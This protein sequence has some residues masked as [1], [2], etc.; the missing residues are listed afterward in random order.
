MQAAAVRRCHLSHTR[1]DA[2]TLNDKNG[3]RRNG[4]LSTPSPATPRD[5]GTMM[6]YSLRSTDVVLLRLPSDTLA[7]SDLRDA[8]LPSADLSGKVC[9]GANFQ[10]ATLRRANFAGADLR[11]ADLS[12]SDLRGANLI[13]ADLLGARF[14]GARYDEATRWPEGFEVHAAGV[15]RISSP[16]A[17]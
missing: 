10:G 16:P 17:L 1:E 14:T 3:L 2:L 7:G 12:E 4:M 8:Y 6:I 9:F 15:V 5:P 11:Q 13:G